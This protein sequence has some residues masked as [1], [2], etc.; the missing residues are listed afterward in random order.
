MKWD[1][2]E[3][4][5]KYKEAPTL[6]SCGYEVMCVFVLENNNTDHTRLHSLVS[7]LNVKIQEISGDFK[8][9]IV[10]C[11]TFTRSSGWQ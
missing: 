5:S 10:S 4:L 6:L 2:H 3:K 11:T 7:V 9:F 8:I 1:F